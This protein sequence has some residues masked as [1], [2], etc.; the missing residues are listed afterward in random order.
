MIFI[1][2]SKSLTY[3]KPSRVFVEYYIYDHFSHMFHKV[4]DFLSLRQIHKNVL[5]KF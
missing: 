4:A 3:Y 2:T 5:K 1:S